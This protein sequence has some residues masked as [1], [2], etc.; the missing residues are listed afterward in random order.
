M[1]ITRMRFVIDG[2]EKT[3]KCDGHH[4]FQAALVFCAAMRGL[5]AMKAEPDPPLPQLFQTGVQM[6]GLCCRK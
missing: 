4:N 5:L 3:L 6:T 1:A 2:S